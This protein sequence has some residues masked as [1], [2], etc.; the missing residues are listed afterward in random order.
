MMRSTFNT[1]SGYTRIPESPWLGT[2][3]TAIGEYVCPVE[4]GYSGKWRVLLVRTTRV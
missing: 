2:C 1:L 3:A 4:P